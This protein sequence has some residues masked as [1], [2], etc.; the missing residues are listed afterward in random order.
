M[1]AENSVAKLNIFLWFLIG[2]LLL[3]ALI[4]NYYFKLSGLLQLV[5]WISVG[6]VSAGL[7][8]QTTQGKSTWVLIQGARTELRKV[9]WPNRQETVRITLLVALIVVVT[10]LF[11]WAI[12]NFVLWV[13]SFLISLN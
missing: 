4:G 8:Y 11:L 9:V 12:D 2:F 5:T 10:A 3:S 6:L 7:A 1:S 13:F